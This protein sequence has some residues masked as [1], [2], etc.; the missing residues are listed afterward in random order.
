M[1]RSNP[2]RWQ[3][4]EHLELR[5]K[6]GIFVYPDSKLPQA[7]KVIHPHCG[8]E[9]AEKGRAFGRMQF[10]PDGNACGACAIKWIVDVFADFAD[11]I[12]PVR[13]QPVFAAFKSNEVNNGK[14]LVVT[15][16]PLLIVLYGHPILDS[17]AQPDTDG[18]IGLT[19]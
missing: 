1:D 7:D 15:A 18:R 8:I 2:G 14:N 6:T 9:E 13:L 10:Q 5:I 19:A 11:G 17:G 3:S 4:A 12:G 16:E